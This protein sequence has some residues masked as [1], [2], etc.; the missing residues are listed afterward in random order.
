MQREL[1][2]TCILTVEVDY[3]PE[4]TC[5]E[6]I[7]SALDHL[8]DT[9]LTTSDLLGECGDPEIGSFYYSDEQ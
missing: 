9:A 6:E 3:D 8:V 2:R 7:A 4:L 1:K 5:P